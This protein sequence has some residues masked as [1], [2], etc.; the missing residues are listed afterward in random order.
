MATKPRYPPPSLLSLVVIC[1][2]TLYYE[3]YL[4]MAHLPLALEP[5]G[6]ETLSLAYGSFPGAGRSTEKYIYR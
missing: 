6:I 3:I 2:Q 5:L 1:H 4:S